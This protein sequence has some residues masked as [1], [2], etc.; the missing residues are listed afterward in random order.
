MLRKPSTVSGRA[1][2]GE[3]RGKRGRS[4]R[5]RHGL[6]GCSGT[7]AEVEEGKTVLEERDVDVEQVCLC[8]CGERVHT[9]V[10]SCHV[11]WCHVMSCH[12]MLCD[13]M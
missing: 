10:M 13:V 3:G 4:G 7:A 12:V 2:E 6:S 1:R 11:M 8:V 9:A 5:D